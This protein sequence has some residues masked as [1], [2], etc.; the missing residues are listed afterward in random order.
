ME[1]S[2]GEPSTKSYT[3]IF[4]EAF[5]Y[6]LSIGMSYELYWYGEPNLVK[7]YREADELRVDR[8]NYEAWLQG[9]YVYQAV[10][11]LYPVFNPFSKQK[12]AEEYLKEPIV[13]TERARNQK[14]MEEGNKMANFLKAWADALKDKGIKNGGS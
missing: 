6:Y 8:M 14:A 7:A 2:V 10:G 5:P 3:E 9:L 11:A 13:I 1:G 12:K 4:N